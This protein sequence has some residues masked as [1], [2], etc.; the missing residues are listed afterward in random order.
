MEIHPVQ[1][2]VFYYSAGRWSPPNGS[3]SLARGAML[4]KGKQSQIALLDFTLPNSITDL[5]WHIWR[6]ILWIRNNPA[7]GK[8]HFIT[9]QVYIKRKFQVP[10]PFYHSFKCGPSDHQPTVRIKLSMVYKKG[11]NSGFQWGRFWDH[12][13]CV[14]DIT[15]YT[16]RKLSRMWTEREVRCVFTVTFPKQHSDWGPHNFRLKQDLKMKKGNPPCT[17]ISFMDK[18]G[19][20]AVTSPAERGS[21][22]WVT[23]REVLV[24]SQGVLFGSLTSWDRE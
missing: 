8:T 2:H 15:T 17:N 13:T 4:T 20:I 5:Q 7:Q 11:S 3:I 19:W 23:R 22:G 9:Q 14:G 24:T 16:Q 6:N 12:R 1:R 10:V 18:Q 21:M